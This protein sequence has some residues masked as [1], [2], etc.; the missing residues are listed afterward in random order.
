MA[1]ARPRPPPRRSSSRRCPRFQSPR[2]RRRSGRRSTARWQSS[3][4]SA[5]AIMC[6]G[7]ATGQKNVGGREREIAHAPG[8]EEGKGGKKEESSF[9]KAALLSG[10]SG[11]REDLHHKG[12][13]Q[14]LW[15]RHCRAQRIRHALREGDQEHGGRYGRQPIDRRLWTAEG[16][17]GKGFKVKRQDGAYYGRGRWDVGRRPRRRRDARQDHRRREDAGDLHL[18]RSSVAEAQVARKPL[19]RSAL[20][21]SCKRR[22]QVGPPP[23]GRL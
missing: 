19:P 9:M 20:P 7:W 15:V 13:T 5:T 17:G 11:C 3:T 2:V 23:C 12:I 14:T 6:A 21:P 10:P 18:Q 4:S 1:R 8:R 22:D 16:V